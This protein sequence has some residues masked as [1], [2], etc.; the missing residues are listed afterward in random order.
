MNM[1]KHTYTHACIQ[2]GVIIGS[3]T[4]VVNQYT[5]IHTHKHACTQTGVIIGSGTGAV[6]FYEDN[7]YQFLSK[8]GGKAGLDSVSRDC[9]TV[10]M[11]N[12][13]ER[14]L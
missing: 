10:R 4:G 14:F 12:P 11:L 3:R 6:E 13:P 8:N 2:T 5:Y 1:Y 9:S 7:C